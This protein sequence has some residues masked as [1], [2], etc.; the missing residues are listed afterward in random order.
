MIKKRGGKVEMHGGR[1]L[2]NT[3]VPGGT[4]KGGFLVS[5][6]NLE[7]ELFVIPMLAL[8]RMDY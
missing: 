5:Q 1:N 4:R 2:Q 6:P 8:L 3:E 7:M